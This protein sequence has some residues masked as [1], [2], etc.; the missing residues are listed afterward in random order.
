MAIYIYLHLNSVIFAVLELLHSFCA[1]LTLDNCVVDCTTCC[2]AQE[3]FSYNLEGVEPQS[4]RST[5]PLLHSG[6]PYATE[7]LKT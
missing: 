3:E 2:A 4:M 5:S 7:C 1:V 6:I